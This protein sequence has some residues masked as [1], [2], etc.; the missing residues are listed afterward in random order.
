MFHAEII[1]TKYFPEL[2][3]RYLLFRQ[4]KWWLPQSLR[5]VCFKFHIQANNEWSFIK[6]SIVIHMAVGIMF[7]RLI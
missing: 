2:D 3:G 1:H 6:I 5:N 7:I 4:G